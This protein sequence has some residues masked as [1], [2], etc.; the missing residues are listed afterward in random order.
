MFGEYIRSGQGTTRDIYGNV[1][2]SAVDGRSPYVT[3]NYGTVDTLQLRDGRQVQ[4]SAVDGDS[5]YI[6]TR[7][8]PQSPYGSASGDGGIL[9]NVK[10]YG[11]Y[12]SLAANVALLGYILLKK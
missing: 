12:A 5:P 4:V 8:N 6:A 11:L 3:S 7:S 1:R 2:S 10:E 9:G